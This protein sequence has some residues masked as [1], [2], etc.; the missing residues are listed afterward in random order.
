MA[1][2]FE[3]SA[4]LL[5]RFCELGG[6]RDQDILVARSQLAQHEDELRTLGDYLRNADLSHDEKVGIHG[7]IVTQRKLRND[8]KTYVRRLE[9]TPAQVHDDAHIARRTDEFK[10]ICALR[11]VV[12]GYVGENDTINLIVRASFTYKGLLYDLGDW[13]IQF[14]ALPPGD[15]FQV[16]CFRRSMRLA[17]EGGYPDYMMTDR[18]F[19]FGPDNKPL[20]IKNFQDERY[21][22][23]I[24]LIIGVINSV[25]E[26]D[27]D[28]IP[29]AFFPTIPATIGA[30]TWPLFT[31][32]PT[33]STS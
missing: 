14:G 25:N 20:I 29:E 31:N 21:F 23:A 3:D 2:R 13:K 28:K 16:L 9:S 12:G 27:V 7:E 32:G 15:L 1:I 19:C 30:V 5:R 33:I 6:D 4:R 8:C 22:Q 18:N 11:H 26:A 17:W 24:Q 10:R